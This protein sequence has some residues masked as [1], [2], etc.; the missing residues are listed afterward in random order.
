MQW[1]LVACLSPQTLASSHIVG[2]LYPQVSAHREMC[3][4]IFGCCNVQRIML[5]FGRVAEMLRQFHTVKNCLASHATFKCPPD[6]HVGKNKSCYLNLESESALYIKTT[7]LGL[8]E[9]HVHLAWNFPKSCSLF[10]DIAPEW[11]HCSC[12]TKRLSAFDGFYDQHRH[13]IPL[14]ILQYPLSQTFAY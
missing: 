14:W 3:S 5:T 6:I 11:Q 7:Y 4:D 10:Q 9:G 1:E 12:N 2:L 13:L 8:F